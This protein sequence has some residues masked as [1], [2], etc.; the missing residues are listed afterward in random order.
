MQY[1]CEERIFAEF[2]A[3]WLDFG[4]FGHNNQTI[5]PIV[6]P[7]VY[8]SFPKREKCFEKLDNVSSSSAA[9]TPSVRYRVGPDQVDKLAAIAFKIITLRRPR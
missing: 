5:L 4:E 7:R 1:L 9:T 2:Q 3:F 8:S 6:L